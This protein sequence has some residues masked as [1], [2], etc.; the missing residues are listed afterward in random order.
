MKQIDFTN[1]KEIFKGYDGA[2]TKKAVIY[3]DGLYM[4]KFP[5]KRP[6]N[7]TNSLR[8]SYTNNPFSEYI[9]CHVFDI[10]GIQSQN[11]LIGKYGDKIVV[12]CEDFVDELPDNILF[13]EFS[14]IENSF[15]ASDDI[16]N[17]RTPNLESLVKIFNEHPLLNPIKKKVVERYW[18]TF[19]VDSLLGNFDRHSANW[20]YFVDKYTG[21]TTLAPIYDCGSCLFPQIDDEVLPSVM[22]STEQ[23]LRR[24]YDFPLAA[25]KIDGNKVNYAKFVTSLD[26]SDC[27]EALSRIAPKINLNEID[28]VIFNTPYMSEIRKDFLS[29]IIKLR[30]QEIIELAYDRLTGHEKTIKK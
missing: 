16:D 4:L 6:S 28:D 24:V 9:G 22:N 25:L 3:E 8:A 26:N 14:Q 19:I 1:C 13:Q 29:K 23:M 17:S 27:N 2:D 15:L 7:D 10:L 21:D 12:A 5:K 18:D 11:T 20:G 30:M